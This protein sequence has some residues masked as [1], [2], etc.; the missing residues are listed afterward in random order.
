MNTY[1]R[2]LQP[3]AVLL[4]LFLILAAKSA[5]A[6]PELQLYIE[7]A[8]YDTATETWLATF[9]S[10]GTSDS[11]RSATL[12]ARGATV[13]FSTFGSRWPTT[14]VTHPTFTLT[15]STTGGYGGFT[16]P[17]TPGTATYLQTR[18]DGSSPLLSNGSPLPSHGEYGPDIAWQEYLL[19]NFTL[20]DSSAGDFI[21]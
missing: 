21:N 4:A 15:S 6:I 3:G 10:G 12:V 20:T 19:G 8:T 17:S 2:F 1:R 18:T 13:A 7:G 11:G 5:Q 14:L 9:P 16:D